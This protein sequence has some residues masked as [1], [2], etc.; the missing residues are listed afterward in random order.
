[1]YVWPK[2]GQRF[3]KKY[4]KPHSIDKCPLM[5][6]GIISSN[7]RKTFVSRDSGVMINWLFNRKLTLKFLA[8]IEFLNRII[9]PSM[10]PFYSKI[11]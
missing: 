7:G 4:T 6:W 8:E 2:P 10:K 3:D 11:F 1:M 5:F 9:V